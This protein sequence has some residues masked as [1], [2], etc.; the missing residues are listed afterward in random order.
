MKLD[1]LKGLFIV[2]SILNGIS[3]KSIIHRL[4]FPQDFW[5]SCLPQ[6]GLT[7]S[8]LEEFALIHPIAIASLIKKPDPFVST[9]LKLFPIFV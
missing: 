4:T 1:M 7:T 8:A 6:K 9:P 5:T 3:S 2:T